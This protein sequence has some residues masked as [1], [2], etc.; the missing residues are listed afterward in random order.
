MSSGHDGI[1]ATKN[2]QVN[3]TDMVCSNKIATMRGQEKAPDQR[4]VVDLREL[5]ALE[6]AAR[7]K[8]VFHLGRWLVPS[9]G[10]GA[11]Y[12]VSL[13]PPACTCED[14]ALRNEPCKH[15]IAARLVAERDGGESAP[16]METEAVP[17]RPT[18]KQ[19][20][21]LYNLAQQTERDRFRELLAD[22]VTGLPEP[23][24]PKTGRRRTPMRDMIYA[25]ALKVFTTL[26][27]RRFA[28]E[29]KDAHA[30]G[31]LGHLMNSVS[32]T[33]YMENDLM[34]PYLLQLVERAARP[35]IGVESNFIPDSTGFSTSRF[36]RWYDEKYGRERSGREW[37]KAHAMVGSKTNVIT[38]CVI[39]GPTA[40]DS[41]QFKPLLEATVAN[42]F[43]IGTVPADKAYLSHDNL[44]LVV[45]HG[46][47]PF[48]PFKVNSVPGESGSLWERMYGYFQFRRPEFLKHYHQRSNV[49]ST[50]SMV[51]AKFRDDVRSRTDTAM[52]NE[53]LLKFLCHNIVVVHQAI[54]E[55]GIEAEFWPTTDG[56]RDV[57]PLRCAV[58]PGAAQRNP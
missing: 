36:V 42:G 56:P 2:P 55:L 46:G 51:K 47:T 17:K 10:S 22:L 9:Q 38:A 31:F 32:V 45:A 49:E 11:T 4:C 18:Y 50:F 15:V 27:S 48:I 37:V 30:L 53:V 7:S 12:S 34:T 21:P 25:S 29:L 33:D 58:K 43:K 16:P 26:S 23:E 8:I 28:C 3:T 20:W 5:K 39:D 6:L 19:N 35:L 13:S 1:V 54:I 44:A 24:Q 57:L 52:K 41:P 40:G 14:F